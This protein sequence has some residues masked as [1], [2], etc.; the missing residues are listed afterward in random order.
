MYFEVSENAMRERLESLIEQMRRAGLGYEQ[1]VLEF[2]KAFVAAGLR[3]HGGNVSKAAPA[4]G[5][6]RNTLTR[7]CT[8]LR[9]EAKGF[10]PSRR[11]PPGSEKAETSKRTSSG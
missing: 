7:L 2:R 1:A 3:Q 9:L 8:E 11:Y 5:V 4:L 6:H 10:R